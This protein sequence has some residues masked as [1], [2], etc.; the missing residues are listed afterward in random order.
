[1]KSKEQRQNSEPR[2]LWDSGVPYCQ[3]RCQFINLDDE[4]DIIDDSP[5]KLDHSMQGYDRICIPAIRRMV[6]Q[7]DEPPQK[8]DDPPEYI[9]ADEL[10]DI[11]GGDSR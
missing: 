11:M 4:G 3:I 8:H 9:M 7:D 6:H 10:Y 1:M 5:C 2:P